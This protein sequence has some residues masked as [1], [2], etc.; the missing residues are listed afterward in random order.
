VFKHDYCFELCKDRWLSKS[1]PLPLSFGDN[2][3]G[4]RD[5][6]KGTTYYFK[7]PSLFMKLQLG[8]SLDSQNDLAHDSVHT[9]PFR[10]THPPPSLINSLV[11]PIQMQDIKL[12]MSSCCR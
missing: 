10:D 5:K 9:P 4:P 1:N 8:V 6:N 12:T 2:I 3:T 11:F 7:N